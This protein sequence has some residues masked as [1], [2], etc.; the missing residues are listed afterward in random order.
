M[1]R[2]RHHHRGIATMAS[3]MMLSIIGI[4]VLGLAHWMN[5]QAK[6][7]QNEAYEIQMRQLWLAGAAFAKA[8]VSGDIPAEKSWEVP[9]PAEL[10]ASGASL[11]V[12]LEQTDPSHKLAVIVL[13]YRGRTTTQQCSFIAAK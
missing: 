2:T 5:M 12:T 4:T 13:T 8:H 7:T 9:L 6:H 10:I 1:K 3:I 11:R